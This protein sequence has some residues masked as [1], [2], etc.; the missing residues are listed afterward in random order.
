[1][2]DFELNQIVD[3]LDEISEQLLYTK[4]VLSADEAARYLKI[5]KHYLYR[6]THQRRV[7][8]YRPSGKKLF[9]SREELDR[10]LLKNPIKTRDEIQ[11]SAEHYTRT[12][13]NPAQ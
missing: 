6:L 2:N 3:R 1:M 8:C 9:F 12:H 10:W 7:P 4:T 11:E 13:P 5:G